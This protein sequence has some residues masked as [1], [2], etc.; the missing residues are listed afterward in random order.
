M[1]SMRTSPQSVSNTYEADHSHLRFSYRYY[2]STLPIRS[3][4]ALAEAVSHFCSLLSTLPIPE[5]LLHCRI[6]V[7]QIHIPRDGKHII[8]AAS[9]LG[10]ADLSHDA[11]VSVASTREAVGPGSQTKDDGA[12]N[13]GPA[14]LIK[15][16]NSLRDSRPSAPAVVEPS[17]LSASNQELAITKAAN[18]PMLH[19]PLPLHA[20]GPDVKI[21]QSTGGVTEAC[22]MALCPPALHYPLP[23]IGSAPP[24][25]LAMVGGIVGG[26]PAAAA[27]MRGSSPVVLLQLLQ[28]MVQH[29]AT[30]AASGAAGGSAFM[31][32]RGSAPGNVGLPQPQ[33]QSLLQAR[34]ASGG[35]AGASLSGSSGR[36]AGV[37]MA[38]GGAH[39]G[40]ASGEGSEAREAPSQ[41]KP[42]ESKTRLP[43]GEE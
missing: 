19:Q 29:N 2:G 35:S 8:E 38:D 39:P 34:L 4:A 18:I 7:S 40:S 22:S 1:G 43:D 9:P 28:R 14:P 11:H 23:V 17:A 13:V 6:Y 24:L 36:G 12:V 26:D 32:Q 20:L 42:K 15:E 41:S 31:V 5:A 16:G 37:G 25:P 3:D 33:I 21:E 10:N 30:H 27:P